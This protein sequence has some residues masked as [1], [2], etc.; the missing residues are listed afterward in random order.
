MSSFKKY[1]LIDPVKYEELIA[2]AQTSKG[3][4]ILVHPNIKA[5]KETDNKMSSILNDSTKSDH[6]KIDEYSSNLDSY[7]RNFKNALEVPKRD[8]ILGE[9]K[10]T[11]EDVHQVQEI[12]NISQDSIVNKQHEN[13]QS[14]PVSYR[15]TATHLTAF[16]NRNKNFEVKNHEL[17]YKGKRV[18]QSDF[19]QLLD[20][21]VRF[22]KPSVNSKVDIDGFVSL[23]R[24][25]GYPVTRLG[26]VRRNITGKS[27]MQG[28]SSSSVGV[29]KKASKLQKTIDRLTPVSTPAKTKA[30]K[31][32][33]VTQSKI[34]QQW[35][36]V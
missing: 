19:S 20:G 8:A 25:E 31:S 21:V 6:Q 29:Q 17:K 30:R 7:L 28:N 16:L 33:T 32:K 22:K 12:P 14:I 13:K 23:L 34:F 11:T 3:N 15:P 1:L 9:K 36:K 35:E 27:D 24:Q 18:F 2:K 10:V 26:Y 5:V 4:D